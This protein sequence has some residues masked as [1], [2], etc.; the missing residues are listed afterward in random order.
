M[1][2]VAIGLAV[3]GASN[4]AYLGLVSRSLGPAAAAPVSVLWTLLNAVGIG[5]YLPLEQ[6]VGRRLSAARA[7]RGRAEPMRRT[8]VY[9]GSTVA[10]IGV[11]TLLANE[12]IAS[13]LLS[14]E[15]ALPAVL[16]AGLAGQALA[17][18]TRGLLAGTGRFRRY[19]LQFVV[20]GVLRTVAAAVLFAAD[21]RSP[22]AFAWV[23]VVAPVVAALLTVPRGSLALLRHGGA[24]ESPAL[25]GSALE[26]SAPESSASESPAAED[27]VADVAAPEG[28]AHG[29]TPDEPV[30]GSGG[31]AGTAGAAPV[32]MG[33]LVATSVAGQLLANAGPIAVA[34]LALPSQQALSGRFVAAVT[35]ARIPLFLFAAVQA[36]F[37]PA[38]ASL[39]ARHDHAG[40]RRAVLRALGATG[41]LG[42]VGTA[43]VLAIG[44]LVLSLLYTPEFLVERDVMGL[45]ALSGALFMLGQVLALALLAQHADRAA[46]IGWTVG[47]VVLVASL[48]LPLDLLVRISVALCTGSLAAAATHALLLRTTLRRAR[49]RQY[50]PALEVIP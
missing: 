49:A 45:V 3:F 30:R 48:A 36:V 26:G 46:A 47:I 15:T 25:E 38:L 41:A 11:V 39:A 18:L 50:A 17:Y 27:P 20:D 23:L 42:V 22:T 35:V 8:L 12:A 40:F 14:G 9:A 16:A 44:P 24:P 2:W 10:A 28:A 6:E 33:P 5:L 1:L 21:V 37:L 32:R 43:G 19:G 13:G 31:P 4:F 7:L 34:L 29:G